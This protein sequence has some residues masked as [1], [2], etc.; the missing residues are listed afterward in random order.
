[1]LLI[2]LS[3]DKLLKCDTMAFVQ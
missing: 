3:S 2:K 1:M